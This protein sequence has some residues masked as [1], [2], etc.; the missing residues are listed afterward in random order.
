[1]D[2]QGKRRLKL[3]ENRTITTARLQGMRHSAYQLINHLTAISGYT[4][5]VL[6]RN[7]GLCIN[8]ELEKVVK[9]VNRASEEVLSCLAS[10]NEVEK[11]H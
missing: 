11:G 6:T 4:Q 8:T 3:E 10:L 7:P 2:E 5:L 9:A 1:M